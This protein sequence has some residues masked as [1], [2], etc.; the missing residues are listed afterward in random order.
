MLMLKNDFMTYTQETLSAL[1]EAYPEMYELLDIDGGTSVSLAMKDIGQERVAVCM[2]GGGAGGPVL[3]YMVNEG[4]ADASVLGLPSAAPNAYAIYETGKLLG[5]KGVIFMYNN[6]MGD[7]VNAQYGVEMLRKDGID[8]YEIGIADDM[9]TQISEARYKRNGKL[10]LIYAVKIAAACAR[11]GYSAE[12]IYNMMKKL[13]ERCATI[14]C[15][16]D[17]EK[18]T[19]GFGAGFSG[20]P[21]VVE[22]PLVDLKDI[23][24]YVAGLLIED[25]GLRENEKAYAL[26]NKLCG[27]HIT[28]AYL[29][30]KYMKDRLESYCDVGKVQFGSFANLNMTVSYAFEFCLLMADEEMREMLEGCAKTQLFWI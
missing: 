6:Y 29:A 2:L 22:R 30:N 28:D 17:E 16:V 12:E 1:V 4:L 27:V 13:N 23:V 19:V 10:A 25:V 24:D 18:D 26:V 9:M 20:E 7:R 8:A 5:K 21:P 14:T 3:H 11:K 15:V